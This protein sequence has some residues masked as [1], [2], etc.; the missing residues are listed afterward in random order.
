MRPGLLGKLAAPATTDDARQDSL[1][2]A[3]TAN[4]PAEQ[5]GDP[6]FGTLRT[7]RSAAAALLVLL[8]AATSFGGHQGKSYGWER[9][10]LRDPETGLVYTQLTNAPVNSR[11]LYFEHPSFTADNQ[12]ILF[13]S[14]RQATRDSGWDLFRVDA[15][16]T[17]LVQLT[18]DEHSIGSPIPA[19]D[20]ARIV[21]AVRGNA[22]LAFNIDTF[23]ERV[24]ARCDEVSS[25]GPST[26]TGDGTYYLACGRSKVDG[27]SMIVR[28]RTDGSEVIT[29]AHGYP[30]NH[31]T[32]NL[33]GTILAFA[34]SDGEYTCDIDG[35]NLRKIPRTQ[36]F[37]HSTWLGQTD[38]RQGTGA[39][40][41]HRI[42][43]AGVDDDSVMNTICNGPYFWHS[44]SS[45]DGEW[46]VSDSNWPI[47]GI[48]LIHVPSGRYTKLVNPESRIGHQDMTHPHPSFNRDATMVVFTSNETGLCQVYSVEIPDDIREELRTGELNH[49]L[50][51]RR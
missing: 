45:T 20:S 50:R 6:M 17:D 47:E 7:R 32:T 21:Y 33:T 29:F 2:D 34:G 44:A 22:L 3:R 43:T 13:Y 26:L 49:R 16:G 14:Q 36:Q 18:D 8:F 10:K 51:W 24:I 31:L 25:L 4:R 38:L 23:E 42:A 41:Q 12:S 15:D 46:I 11:V 39:H 19:P 1:S 48:F 40:G 30:Y 9:I 37:A 35:D 27:T 5:Q 28:F